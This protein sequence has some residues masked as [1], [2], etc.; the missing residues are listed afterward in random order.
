MNIE[1]LFSYLGNNRK[2]IL[3]LFEHRDRVINLNE[4]EDLASFNMLEVLN[5]YEIIEVIDSKIVL[6]L[7]IVS[8]LEE[9]LDTNEIID[10]AI[11]GTILQDLEHLIQKA[12]EF[13]QKQQNYIPKIRRYIIKIDN[14]LFKN[15]EKLRI[16]INRVYKSADEF[17]LKLKELSFYKSRLSE[18]EKAIYSFDNFLDKY[19]PF[20][21]S[22]YNDD[23]ITI[24]NIIKTNKLELF[25]TLIPLTQDVISYI[26][27][28]E[29]KN[30]FVEKIVK[31]KELK[32]SYEI[33]THTNIKEMIDEFEVLFKPISISSRLD[34]Q[35]IQTEEFEKILKKLS[36]KN[37][38]KT[39]SIQTIN[40]A[41]NSIVQDDLFLNIH[42]LHLKFRSTKL[43]LIEF[44]VASEL[45]KNS[46]IKDISQ[47]Y[48][49]ML[50]MY[51]DEY[52][53]KPQT[54]TIHNINFAKIYNK[55]I[56]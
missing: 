3:Y 40:I 13:K 49:K 51:E 54:I 14:I 28:L 17:K 45:L 55:G 9:Y 2:L 39:K 20:L 29:N 35:I 26:N 56:L 18:F 21:N 12:D 34:E 10:I 23:L 53:F 16:H 31:L 33:N 43:S 8:F 11:I 27:K 32:D 44:L 37:R 7:R 48:C 25:R 50:L 24:L 6:D 42:Q 1:K 47:I 52:I 38:L 46:P 15:L 36:S 19:T 4:I 41:P 22:F 5:N 30:I